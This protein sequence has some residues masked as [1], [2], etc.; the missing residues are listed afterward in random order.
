MLK[1]IKNV[2]NT[3]DKKRLISNFTSLAILQILNY[4]LPLVTFPYL[5]RVLGVENFGLLAFA[6]ATIA[7]FNI[8]TDY[9]FNLTATREVAIYRDSKEK[10][11]EI[12]SSV[13]LIKCILMLLSFGLLYLLVSHVDKFAQHKEVYF[14]TFG[15]VIGQVLFPIWFFQGMERMKYITYLNILSKVIF[16]IAIFIF[17]REKDDVWL[18]PLLT[19]LGFIIAGIYSLYLIKKEFGVGFNLQKV[20]TLTFY[21]KD[22]WH[23]FLQQ[24]YVSMYG[25]INIVLLGLLSTSTVV[26]Y[27]NIVEKILS[28][29]IALFTVAV[30][31]YY[32]F[33]VKVFKRNIQSYFSQINKVF[34]AFVLLSLA[35]EVCIYMFDTTIVDLVMST[36]GDGSG[37]DIVVNILRI[38]AFGLVFSSL[39]QFY[40]QI[41]ITLS[42]SKVLSQLS[43]KMMWLNLLLSPIVIYF[44]GV[45]GLALLVILRQ[46][47]VIG[48]C[49]SKIKSFKENMLNKELPSGKTYSPTV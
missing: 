2:A 43:F 14:L 19:S 10:L 24:F 34:I 49:F 45:I 20:S 23:V 6:T 37:N 29:P 44:F 11:V 21:L 16:T 15:I 17:V 33:A 18:V 22:G 35:M 38:L 26:G 36:K 3:E 30:Q 40:T 31:A 39:G 8:L 5:V 48:F 42:K 7:Y 4:A 27:Y 13:M 28:V 32:P 1:K 46:I 25:P 41:F 9:G 47:L 12:F